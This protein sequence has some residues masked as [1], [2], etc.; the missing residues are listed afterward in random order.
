MFIASASKPPGTMPPA[1]DYHHRGIFASELRDKMIDEAIH[2]IP[3]HYFTSALW[4]HSPSTHSKNNL[5][6]YS[7]LTGSISTRQCS[8]TRPRN[9]EAGSEPRKIICQR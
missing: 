5:I 8:R 6:D 7:K 2:F 1:R 3:C 4:L 9:N